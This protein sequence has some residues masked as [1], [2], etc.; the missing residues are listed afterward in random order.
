MFPTKDIL[1]PLTSWSYCCQASGPASS[2]QP[3]ADDTFVNV[4]SIG[5]YVALALAV[6]A[7]VVAVLQLR[8]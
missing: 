2:S 1:E 3:N 8:S 4:H 6:A 7:T 5:A